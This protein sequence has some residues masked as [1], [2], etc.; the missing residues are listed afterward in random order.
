MPR[1]SSQ[2]PPKR[3]GR[4]PH[5]ARPL[6]CPSFLLVLCH[7]ANSSRRWSSRW[8]HDPGDRDRTLSSTVDQHESGVADRF[9][10]P[11]RTHGGRGKVKRGVAASKERSK[12]I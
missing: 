12:K 9:G 4:N 7:V 11:A 2:G 3:K 8:N 1:A 6:R 10:A 5:G